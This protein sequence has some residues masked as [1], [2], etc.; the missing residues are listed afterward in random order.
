MGIEDYKEVKGLQFVPV[1]MAPST[2]VY[3]KCVKLVNNK[4]VKFV[5]KTA[6]YNVIRITLSILMEIASNAKLDI[7]R[8]VKFAYVNIIIIYK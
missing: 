2:M 1:E 5:T 3:H 8:R 4:I 6:A 7:N